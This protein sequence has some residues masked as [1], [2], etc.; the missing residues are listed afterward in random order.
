MSYIFE[1][2]RIR[3]IEK[4][5]LDKAFFEVLINA[6]S[7]EE[8]RKLLEEKGYENITEAKQLMNL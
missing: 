5:L 7:Y 6:G 1:V 8:A 3:C 4:K 2:A